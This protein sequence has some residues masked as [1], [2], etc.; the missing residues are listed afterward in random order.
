MFGRAKRDV[1]ERRSW[2]RRLLVGFNILLASLLLVGVAGVGFA[3]W[4]FGQVS[5]IDLDSVLGR[6]EGPSAPMNVLLVGSDS[7]SGLDASG[8]RS[9]GNEN[10]VPGQRSDTIMVL[11][12]DPRRER[13]AILSL[14]RDLWVT[15]AGTEGKQRINTAFDGGPGRLIQTIEQ[16]FSIGIDHYVQVDFQGFKGIVEAVDGVPVRF[17]SPVRDRPAG[18]DI[19]QPGCTT[20]S[21]D[22]ALAYVRSRNY[23][24][25]ESGRWRQD[26]RADLSRI[27][28]QQDFVRR[29]IRKAISRGARNPV[30]LN[31]LISAGVENVQLDRGFSL[32]DITRLGRRFQSLDANDVEMMTLPSTASNVGGAAVLLP[33]Q[34]E[35]RGTIERFLN[36]PPEQQ[37]TA[38]IPPSTITVRVLNGTGAAGQASETAAGLKD[39]GF[40]VTGTGDAGRYG[41]RTT[42]LRYARGL[43]AEAET[44]AKFVGG[45][46]TLTEDVSLQGVEVVLVTG[47]TFSGITE[48]GQAPTTTTTAAAAETDQP[49]GSEDQSAC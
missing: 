16:N 24:T 38:A 29:V 6:D 44:V 31:S 12:I 42:V 4:R 47:D 35:A 5:K 48:P 10:D 36:G 11:R 25:Y 22:Q 30:T 14:P 39:A 49:T 8:R 2:S 32:R 9:F 40:V 26:P 23:E 19:R 43:R 37:Q 13:A 15:I 20:L 3:Q 45:A 28:R 33:K 17:D 7:R 21:G 46:T 1:G 41:N 18:L 34:P 27:D